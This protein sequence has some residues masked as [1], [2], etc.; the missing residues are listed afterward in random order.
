MSVRSDVSYGLRGLTKAPGFTLAVTLSLALGIGA[1][2][3]IFSVVNALLFHPA[4]VV[5]PERVVALRVNY[6]KLNLEKIGVSTTDFA[7]IRNDRKVF[8]RAALLDLEGLNYTGGDSPQRLQ[9][10]FVTPEWFEVFGVSPMLGRGFRGE[11]DQP[12][13]NHVAVLSH[14]T[15]NRLF[16]ADRSLLA[17][18]S[19]SIR[20]RIALLA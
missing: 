2:A 12:G 20:H 5:N 18:A 6:K 15:W 9:S 19:N 14:A 4:G 7:D 1:N 11:E 17:A 3:A 8:S 10:A 13:A 16:G